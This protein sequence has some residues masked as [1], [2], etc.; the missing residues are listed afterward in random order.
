MSETVES[1]QQ[2]GEFGLT[3]PAIAKSPGEFFGGLR[4]GCPVARFSEFDGFWALSRYRDVYDAALDTD[5]F[6]ST[7][8]V[9]I[10][11]IPHEPVPCLEM[12]EPDHRKYRKPMQGWFSVKRIAAWRTRS[13]PSST[14]A[15]TR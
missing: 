9:T 11:D 10:P 5:A 3:D 7:K 4:S 12:D 15:S 2:P 14:S 6:S 1:A 13:A 8:G